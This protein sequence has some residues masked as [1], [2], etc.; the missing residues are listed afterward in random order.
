MESDCPL[1]PDDLTIDIF[2][3]DYLLHSGRRCFPIVK[4]GKL[5]GLVTIH[6]LKKVPRN[7]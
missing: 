4:G 5:L 7:D 3:H 2:V 1:V 6:G